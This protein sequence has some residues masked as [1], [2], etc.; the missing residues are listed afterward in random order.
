MNAEFYNSRKWRKK[1]I[2]ILKRDKFLCKVC[3]RYGRI[4]EATTVHHIKPLENFPELAF[5]S[6]NL[7][8]ICAACH[9]NLHPEKRK[10]GRNSNL[11]G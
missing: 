7:I 10:H 6:D 9:A 5:K 4:T 2:A 1:R 3:S 11:R 8:S